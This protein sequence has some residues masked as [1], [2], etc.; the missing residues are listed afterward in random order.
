MDREVKMGFSAS[1]CFSE[2]AVQAGFEGKAPN[3]SHEDTTKRHNKLTRGEEALINR[4]AS[5]PLYRQLKR[6]LLDCIESGSWGPGHLV[7]S[8]AELIRQYGVSRTTVRQAL[9]ELVSEGVLRRE[10]GRGT[11]VA[12][13]KLEQ[14]LSE[15][16]SFT[17]DIRAK[18]HHPGSITL[19]VEEV[20]PPDRIAAQL[21]MRPQAIAVRLERLRTVDGEAVG[22]HT[23]YLPRTLLGD[24]TLEELRGE[25]F[26]LYALLQRRLNV[27]F[28]EAIETLEAAAADAY[29]SRLL[30]VGKGS[31]VLQ[32]ERLT[33]T[34]EG[35]PLEY[36]DI[37]YRADRYKY[38]TRLRANRPWL[39]GETA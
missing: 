29:Q 7:P 35:A 28:G 9:G 33:L 5:V 34:A 2:I 26:S 21:Q 27:R 38:V 13:P 39:D 22:L 14:P 23:A 24:I 31:P 8:E 37:V 18:G 12:D 4:E 15:L 6:G 17:D 32:L 19:H 20:I 10:Q 36:V 30:E 25:D 1:N 16:T 11:F 3:S